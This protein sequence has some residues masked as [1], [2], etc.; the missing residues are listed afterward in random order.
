LKIENNRENKMVERISRESQTRQKEERP[1]EWKPP[2]TLEAPEPPVGYK[3]RWIR[4][5]VLEYDDRNNVHKRRREGYELVK[6][7][8]YPEF[9][10]PVIDEGKNA[11]VIG[12]G[13]LVLARIPEEIAEQRNKHYQNVAQNQM[14]AVDRDWMR[15]NNPNM[16]KLAPQRSTSVT[17]GSQKPTKD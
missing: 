2:S 15:E 3:H 17:F 7:E 1:T 14:E 5:S 8:E 9:D 6:A 11:G 13:G 16:P 10:A 4:E 12:V